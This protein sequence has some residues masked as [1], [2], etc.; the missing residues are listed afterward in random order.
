MLSLDIGASP[1]NDL[2]TIHWDKRTYEAIRIPLLKTADLRSKQKD[3]LIINLEFQSEF[4]LNLSFPPQQFGSLFLFLFLPKMALPYLVFQVHHE[5][6][7]LRL[8]G[9]SPLQLAN[10]STHMAIWVQSWASAAAVQSITAPWGSSRHGAPAQHPSLI[11]SDFWSVTDRE[12]S[13]WTCLWLSK[14][15]RQNATMEIPIELRLGSTTRNDDVCSFSSF[16]IPLKSYRQLHSS[17]GFVFGF[18]V[19]NTVEISPPPL[20]WQIKCVATPP[21]TVLHCFF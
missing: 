16:L 4:S 13:P 20:C 7:C 18:M 15:L 8:Q 21:E 11:P 1:G 19:R 3:I 2:K 14:I 17:R 9:Y 10:G 5:F 12:G 6:L